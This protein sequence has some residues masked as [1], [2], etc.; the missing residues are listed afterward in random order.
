V[1]PPSFDPTRGI[2]PLSPRGALL[3][4][5]GAVLAAAC[6]RLARDPSMSA[7]LRSA[8]EW[9]VVLEIS[10]AAA[11]GPARWTVDLCA[12]DPRVRPGGNA[13]ANMRAAF[14]AAGFSSVTRGDRGAEDL[15]LNGDLRVSER[16][17]Q[18]HGGCV[19][20]PTFLDPVTN[21]GASG[22]DRVFPLLSPTAW[23]ELLSPVAEPPPWPG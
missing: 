19:R 17:H 4:E 1:G 14:T 23:V 13:A 16:V 8:V 10:I 22:S 3:D 12:G 21:G 7:H 5:P 15:M 20:R 18:V 2:P 9:G 6:A 11:S